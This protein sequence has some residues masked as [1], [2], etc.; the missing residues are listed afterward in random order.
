MSV[1]QGAFVLPFDASGSRPTVC[2]ASP[3]DMVEKSRFLVSLIMD[4]STS[5]ITSAVDSQSRS[6]R[7][8][9]TTSKG[10]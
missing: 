4:V 3:T 5:S 9:L 7:T 2:H 1:A 10:I 6:S 8:A